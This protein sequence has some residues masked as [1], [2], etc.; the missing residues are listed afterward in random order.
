M[1]YHKRLSLLVFI[2]SIFILTTIFLSYLLLYDQLVMQLTLI[3]TAI[4][5][6][7]CHHFFSIVYKLYKKAWEYASIG[8]LIIILKIVTISVIIAAVVQQMP[9]KVGQAFALDGANDYFSIPHNVS[10]N[11]IRPF[12]VD[13]WVKADP[14]QLSPDHQFVIIDKSHGF[15]D[16]TGWALQGNSDGTVSFFFG[17]GGASGDPSNFVGVS[18]PI[19]SWM[20]SGITWQASLRAVAS[21]FIWMVLSQ[22]QFVQW[23]SCR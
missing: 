6:L 13:A 23:F 22:Y 14:V 21:K 18:T 2:D 10:L 1:A 11:P 15:N 20:I 19:A 16:A 7:I 9:G 8:E 5:L 3:V 12:S 17:K 4:T